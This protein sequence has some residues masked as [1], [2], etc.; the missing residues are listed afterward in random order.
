MKFIINNVH[1]SIRPHNFAC[2]VFH[3]KLLF[4]LSTFFP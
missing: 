1:A 3:L 4:V 2:F